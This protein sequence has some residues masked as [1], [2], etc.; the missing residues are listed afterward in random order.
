MSQSPRPDDPGRA[1]LVVFV[2]VVVVGL[3]SLLPLEEMS[4]GRLTNFNLLADI[5]E[6]STSSRVN[7]EAEL[8]DP[9]LLDDDSD[10]I[11]VDTSQWTPDSLSAP[12]SN[13]SIERSQ[14]PYTA[15]RVKSTTY[16]DSLLP[17]RQA[18]RDEATGLVVIEDYTDGRGLAYT[19]ASLSGSGLTRIAVIGDSYIEGDIFCQDLRALLQ[20]TYGGHGVGYVNMHS[21]FPGFRRSVK[22]GGE[23]WQEFTVQSAGRNAA[24]IDLAEHYYKPEGTATATYQGVKSP[25]RLDRWDVSQ[26]LFIAP[27]G[28]DLQLTLG[29]AGTRQRQ[30]SKSV[31]ASVGPQAL[32]FKADSVGWNSF[33]VV[34][35]D[36]SLVAFGVWLNDSTGVAL[37]CMSSRGYSGVTLTQVNPRLCQD[38]AQWVDYQ[39]IILEFGINAM[40]P[41]Q[42]NFSSYGKRIVKVIDHV[43]ECYPRADILLMGIGDRG[44]KRDGEVHSMEGVAYM[45]EE[46][47][48]AARRAHCLFWDTREAQ[49]GQDAIVDWV[50]RGLANKDYI[51]MTHKGG[52]ELAQAFYEALRHALTNYE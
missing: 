20:K 21:D 47:R 50:S 1:F 2:A 8:L 24:Y 7:Q 18:P 48:T 32:T 46:Q 40:S 37:D 4:G 30:V 26:V 28:A 6:R 35:S 27:N 15:L 42:R 25:A 41:G 34:C 29:A 5:M 49:G 38:M 11:A 52:Q 16:P 19:A 45:I 14:Y 9:A 3:L 13:D 39:L 43:R 36:P 17:P 51:H 44:E 10:S 33:G 23:G 31:A 22:Q 12:S